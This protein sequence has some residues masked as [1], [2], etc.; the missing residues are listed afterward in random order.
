MISEIYEVAPEIHLI[1]LFDNTKANW[2]TV[3]HRYWMI[4]G[5]LFPTQAM[6]PLN[7]KRIWNLDNKHKETK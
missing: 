5:E 7:A 2:L 3:K 6:V 4:Y 1:A